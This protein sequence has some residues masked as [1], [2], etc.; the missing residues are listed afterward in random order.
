[1]EHLI[2]LASNPLGSAFVICSI[3]FVLGT[4]LV[5]LYDINSNRSHGSLIVLFM[6]LTLFFFVLGFSLTVQSAS[7][8]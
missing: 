1:M 4:F 7:L 3:V 6:T 5:V 2:N 8:N